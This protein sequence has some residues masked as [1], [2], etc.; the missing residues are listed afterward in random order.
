[1]VSIIATAVS[2]LIFGAM[3]MT[4]LPRA[5]Q[6]PGVWVLVS[7]VG[8]P[9]FLL[10]CAAMIAYPALIILIIIVAFAGAGPKNR[11]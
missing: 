6:T 3:I 4:Q 9:L 7:W 2:F 5:W 8:I 10:L 11:R 1:M